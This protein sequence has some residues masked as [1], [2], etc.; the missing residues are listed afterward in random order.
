MSLAPDP[1]RASK[2]ALIV[3]ILGAEM[4]AARRKLSLR[5]GLRKLRDALPEEWR[6]PDSALAKQAEAAAKAVC[7]DVILAH[8]YRTYSFGALLAARDG[9]EL[10]REAL[11]VASI[12][13][14]LGLSEKHKDEEG[15][16]EWVG[17]RL[18]HR[19]CQD[20]GIVEERASLI[21][22]AVALHSSVGI[23]DRLAPEI[24][25]VHLG[26]GVDLFGLQIDEVPKAALAQILEEQPRDGFK[27]CL[28]AC[29]SHQAETKPDS[30][31]AGLVGLGMNG[32]IKEQLLG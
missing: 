14:D 27:T 7:Q 25:M 8:S 1:G 6:A 21:H 26:A 23:A 16:F 32:R 5:L 31:I 30:H 22:D 15:S 24:A 17:A 13:H 3:R 12:L 28:S 2:T 10:D 19:F 4:R 20:R 18:A 29:T 9:L 11:F